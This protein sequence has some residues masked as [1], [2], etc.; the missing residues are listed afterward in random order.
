MRARRTA[1]LLQFAVL[2]SSPGLGLAESAVGVPA[3]AVDA[4]SDQSLS[5][6][7]GRARPSI[8]SAAWTESAGWTYVPIHL[9]G[10]RRGVFIFQSNMPDAG[11]HGVFWLDGE[12]GSWA[13]F[14]FTGD[15]LADAAAAAEQQFA[16][17]AEL[18]SHPALRRAIELEQATTLAFASAPVRPDEQHADRSNAPEKSELLE[19]TFLPATSRLAAFYVAGNSDPDALPGFEL[20]ED[21]DALVVPRRIGPCVPAPRP[22]GGGSG[23]G[24]RPPRPGPLPIMIDLLLE[25]PAEAAIV[26]DGGAGAPTSCGA[27]S[28]WQGPRWVLWGHASDG[29]I[30][31]CIYEYSRVRTRTCVQVVDCRRI[32]SVQTHREVLSYR[33]CLSAGPCPPQPACDGD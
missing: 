10:T 9:A 15:S 18:R 6:S 5:A 29:Q 3:R 7:A 17:G 11:R 14:L 12:P 33:I 27:W 8:E 2:C 4:S 23:P 21:A 1:C 22:T 13:P 24:N 30:Y 19:T 28:A 25:S 26:P 16:H 32:S 31:N 20:A